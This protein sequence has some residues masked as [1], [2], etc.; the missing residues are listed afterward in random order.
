MALLYIALCPGLRHMTNLAAGKA[1]KCIPGSPVQSPILWVE[2]RMDV[3]GFYPA[4]SSCKPLSVKITSRITPKPWIPGASGWHEPVLAPPS[5]PWAF[6]I[7][8]NLH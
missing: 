7:R 2:K 3:S 5:I 6:S 4:R 1:K 8:V